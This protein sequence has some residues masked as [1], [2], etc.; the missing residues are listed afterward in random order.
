MLSELVH[1]N[2]YENVHASNESVDGRMTACDDKIGQW[3]IMQQPTNERWSGGGGGGG[4][5]VSGRGCTGEFSRA[6]AKKV[7][8]PRKQQKEKPKKC[9]EAQFM[10]PPKSA[11]STFLLRP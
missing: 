1:T 6:K 4:G 5:S 3:T 10:P 8:V 7:L 9:H 2:W 11:I